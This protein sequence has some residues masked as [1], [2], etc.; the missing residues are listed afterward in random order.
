MFTNTTGQQNTAFGRGALYSSNGDSNT[1]VGYHAL[2][3]TTT[4][5]DNVAVGR[6]AL[7]TSTTGSENIAI[8]KNAGYSCTSSQNVF[9]GGEGC[10]DSVSSG[11]ECV[12][13]GAFAGTA[14]ST[15]S[16][17]TLIG[18]SAGSALTTGSYN[19]FIGK[20]TG[21]D[22]TT[23]DGNVHLGRNT[24]GS[25]AGAIQIVIGNTVTS[26]GDYTFTFGN[27]SLGKVYNSYNSNASWTRSSDERKKKEIATNT[28]CGLNF[29]NDLRTVTYKWKSP[30]EFPNTFDGYDASVT[31]PSHANKMYGFIAQEVKATLDKHN[32]T[33]FN[34]WTEDAKGEQG[35]SYEMFVM[36]LVK[37]VQELSAKNDALAAEVEQL[38][39]QLNN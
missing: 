12:F 27:N 28:D 37:A 21:R 17:N 2:Y 18:P 26:A 29:I 19:T 3:N 13:M 24:Y 14:V 4:G 31:E 16:G 22:T 11:S 33:D 5:G 36:P 8:G 39:S 23:G 30:S 10:G 38:K 7:Y 25:A 32:I 35:I 15:G 6:A 9:V 20:D 34:G 1:A